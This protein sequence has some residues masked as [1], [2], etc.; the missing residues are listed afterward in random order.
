VRPAAAAAA[1]AALMLQLML[2]LYG[3]LLMIDLT[4]PFYQVFDFDTP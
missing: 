2:L 3:N 4:Q 1:T